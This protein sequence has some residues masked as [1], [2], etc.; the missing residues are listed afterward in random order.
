MA[1]MLKFTPYSDLELFILD[2]P[3]VSPFKIAEDMVDIVLSS[4][5]YKYIEMQIESF[6]QKLDTFLKASEE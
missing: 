1:E 5:E 6:L 3:G 2:L 4:Y